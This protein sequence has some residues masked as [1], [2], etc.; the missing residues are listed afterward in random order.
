[1]SFLTKIFG[2]R[3]DRILRKLRK[4]VAKINKMEPAFEALSDDKLRAKTDEFRS[5]LANGETL[6]QLLPEAFATVREAGKRVLGM[7]HFDVQLIGGMVLHQGKITEMKTGEG[8]TLVA[9]CPVYLNALAGHG[10]HV[11]TVNDYL[12]KRDRDQMSRLYGF[13]G[14]SSGVILNGL[15]TEQ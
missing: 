1:M 7:R 10:V 8:K 11:I 14:L 2:S 9:T 6:Q 15:P 5:R 13:L 3:N 12:A 4:Q